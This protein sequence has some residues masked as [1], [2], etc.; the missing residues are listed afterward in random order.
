MGA[1]PTT[2]TACPRGG[3]HTNVPANP[4]RAAAEAAGAEVTTATADVMD[5]AEQEPPDGADAI[6]VEVLRLITAQAQTT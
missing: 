5:D 1:P 4:A 2:G 6:V 3:P